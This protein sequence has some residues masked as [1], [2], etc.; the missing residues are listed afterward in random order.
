MNKKIS[1]DLQLKEIT[2]HLLRLITIILILIAIA[3]NRD[4]K[5]LG[6]DLSKDNSGNDVP[7]EIITTDDN[8]AIVINTT[9]LAKDAMG[10]AG[11]TP[12]TVTIKDGIVTDILAAKNNET[13][14]F[15]HEAFN[16]LS[17]KWKGK[18]VEDIMAMKVDGVSGATMSSDALNINMRLA[19]MQLP[20]DNA[21]GGSSD[22]ASAWSVTKL[23]MLIVVA[24]GC[25]L[26]LFKRFREY[27]TLWLC[28][29][30]AVLGLWG[31]TF[32]SYA[33]FVN[34]ISNG[35]NLL[36]SL[37]VLLMLIAAFIYPFFGKKSY[38]CTWICPMGS[39]QELA[40]KVNKN[41]KLKLSPKTIKTLNRFNEILWAVLMLFM[42]T[43]VWFDW[44]DYELFTAFIFTAASPVV[45]VVALVFI[46]ISL[47]VPRPY[48]RFICP[49]GCL[50]RLSQ[51]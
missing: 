6:N 47:F 33:L 28:V 46:I 49:T 43:G 22:S 16:Y 23:I 20:S 15:F 30:V 32:L 44:M 40:G 27:R 2:S 31:G 17:N 51:N 7:S 4:G 38:Y 39:L 50:F 1:K 9:S 11:P 34:W 3:L 35:T 10:Y 12:I 36:S 13:P 41:H 8:G 48:C 42:L 19:L 5:L 24:L 26:P 21:A 29:N 25:I 37:S 45:I 18:N 14:E